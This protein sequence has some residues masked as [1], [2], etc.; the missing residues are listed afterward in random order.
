MRRF[1]RRSDQLASRLIRTVLVHDSISDD[2]KRLLC[3]AVSLFF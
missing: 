1:V 2:R 3:Q